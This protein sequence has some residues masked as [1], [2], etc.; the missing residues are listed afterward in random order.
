[1]SNSLRL[2]TSSRHLRYTRA[3]VSLGHRWDVAATEAAQREPWHLARQLP[4]NA[5]LVDAR[6][7][8]QRL[9]RGD[10]DTVICHGLDELEAAAHANAATVVVFHATAAGDRLYGLTTPDLRHRLTTAL[11]RAERVF[12]AR[13]VRET[14]LLEGEIIS[15]PAVD[16]FAGDAPNVGDEAAAV[17]IDNF[18]DERAR[19]AGVEP[20]SD[21]LRG[22]PCMVMTADAVRTGAASRNRVFVTSP[23]PPYDSA[24]SSSMI[25]AMAAG[26]PVVSTAHTGSPIEH[27]RTGFIAVDTAELRG[28]VLELVG[29]RQLAQT[30]GAQARAWVLETLGEAQFKRAWRRVLGRVVERHDASR[31]PLRAAS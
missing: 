12:V 23:R 10:Y 9:D 4:P 1:M 7:A 31:P 8:Q 3:L 27:G 19:L 2:L 20:L 15:A 17:R 11:D 14:W 16:P 5:R 21:A 24:L 22:L 18:D 29:D 6:T 30:M 13:D 25:D 26:L 28:F